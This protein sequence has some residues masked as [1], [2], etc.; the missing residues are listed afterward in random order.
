MDF[1]NLFITLIIYFL[2]SFCFLTCIFG[3]GRLINEFINL[4]TFWLKIEILNFFIGLIFL[5]FLG[6]LISFFSPISDLISFL[7]ITI[8]II[9]YLI[10]FLNINNKN[11]ELINT[12][13]ILIISIAFSFYAGLNDDYGYHYETIKNYKFFP[14]NEIDH[15]RW[16]SYN[17][18]WLLINSIFYLTFNTTS[19]FVLTGLIYSIA[20]LDLW[21]IYKHNEDGIQNYLIE[22]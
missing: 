14:V 20:I 4:D 12:L 21:K 19:L 6:I 7:I 17:S 2:T 13:I 3:Y 10:K 15:H 1:V 22:E 11:K 16:I 18:H 9:F 5:G 8:G